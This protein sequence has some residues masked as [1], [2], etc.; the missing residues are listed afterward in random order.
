MNFPLIDVVGEVDASLERLLSEAKTEMNQIHPDAK[1]LVGLIESLVYSGGKRI[2][3][4]LV[5]TGFRATGREIDGSVIQVAASVE[6][7]HTFALIHDDLM[8]G[9]ETRR[10]A[11]SVHMQAAAL[12]PEAPNGFPV[13]AAMLV[14]DLAFALSDRAYW[15]SGAPPEALRRA[16]PH[17]DRMRVRLAAGQYL[18]VLGRGVDG[19]TRSTVAQAK[20]ASYTTTGPL[21]IGASMNDGGPRLLEALQGWGDMAGE[22]FQLLNDLQENADPAGADKVEWLLARAKEALEP[23]SGH[24]LHEDARLVLNGIETGMTGAAQIGHQP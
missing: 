15:G 14:G 11:P 7:L 12:H 9:S 19:N 24:E 8:D 21:L 10:G 3:P 16:W 4:L 5:C 2:R 20:T 23:L 6:L 1:D 17:L 13:S 18:D 22:A